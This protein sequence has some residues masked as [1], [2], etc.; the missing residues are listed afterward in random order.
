MT[1]LE[2]K[3]T[4]PKLRLRVPVILHTGQ[5]FRSDQ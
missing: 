1:A 5:I 2:K 3:E 4:P